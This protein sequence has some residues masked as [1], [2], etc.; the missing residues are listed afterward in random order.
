[1]S[2]HAH[3]LTTIIQGVLLQELCAEVEN[4]ELE[5]SSLLEEIEAM[6]KVLCTSIS[7]STNVAVDSSE[8][9]G[10]ALAD[11][12]KTQEQSESDKGTFTLSNISSRTLLLLFQLLGAFSLGLI[13]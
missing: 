3:H 1:M 5:V 10:E 9:V 6:K 4:S 11:S 8:S 13:L 12:E 7:Q 2:C